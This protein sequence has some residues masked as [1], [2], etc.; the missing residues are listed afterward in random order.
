L[1]PPVFLSSV[2]QPPQPLQHGPAIQPTT[3]LQDRAQGN[4]EEDEEDQGGFF[5]QQPGMMGMLGRGGHHRGHSLI[6]L[7]IIFSLMDADGDGTVSLQE[8]QTAQERVFKAMDTDHD[9]T[10]TF[11]E[12]RAF[13]QGR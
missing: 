3:G 12:M 8:W 13:F 1:K 11:G 5:H 2:C 6:G 9:G 10:V 4:E 7:R